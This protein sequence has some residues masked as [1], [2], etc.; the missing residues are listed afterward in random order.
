MYF[1]FPGAGSVEIDVIRRSDAAVVYTEF[2]P[3]GV[4]IDGDLLVLIRV[5][6]E[7]DDVPDDATIVIEND[8]A[9]DDERIE[10]GTIDDR[11]APES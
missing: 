3:A 8:P 1:A 9:N 2:T 7:N 11:S 4:H 10:F 6:P 5:M